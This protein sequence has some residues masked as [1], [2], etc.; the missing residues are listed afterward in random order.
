MKI[1]ALR[2]ALALALTCAVAACRLV[3]GLSPSIPSTTTTTTTTTTTSTTTTTVPPVLFVGQFTNPAIPDAPGEHISHKTYAGAGHAG[4]VYAVKFPSTLH[5]R[6]NARADNSRCLLLRS[7]S[8]SASIPPILPMPFYQLDTEAGNARPGYA[9]LASSGLTLS[10]LAAGDLLVLLV[11]ERPI[12][13]LRL[14]DAS[15]SPTVG[16]SLRE[17]RALS[18]MSPTTP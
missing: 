16:F 2:F 6:C 11:A 14:F 5:R 8:S 4:R 10:D 7:A 12:A 9:L 17:H 3:P 18:P 13:M 15:L 1:P